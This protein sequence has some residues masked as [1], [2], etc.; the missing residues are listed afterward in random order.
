MSTS[1][2]VKNRHEGL[3]ATEQRLDRVVDFLRLMEGNFQRRATNLETV[4]KHLRDEY[5]IDLLEEGML[6]AARA[7]SEERRRRLA[8]LLTTSFSQEDLKYAESKK[9]LNLLRDLTDPELLMLV[10]YATPPAMGSEYHN[11]LTEMHPD[12]LQPADLSLG[13]SQDEID[14]GAL[15]DS[16]KNTLLRLDVLEEEKKILRITSLGELLLRYVDIPTGNPT[17]GNKDS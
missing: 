8:N 16:Y 10:F 3:S 1:N 5:G 12:V 11:R 14:L 15:Q 2:I 6:Q 17:E 7:V 9:M 13:T 4:K